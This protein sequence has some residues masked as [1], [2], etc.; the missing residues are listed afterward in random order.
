MGL[1]NVRLKF[2]YLELF[3]IH[4]TTNLKWKEKKQTKKT[5]WF[6]KYV[7]IFSVV[8]ALEVHLNVYLP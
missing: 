8:T 5:F 3:K 2:N 1:T 4:T 6:F 7:S